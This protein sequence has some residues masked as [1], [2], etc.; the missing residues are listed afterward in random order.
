MVVGVPPVR[1]S[2]DPSALRTRVVRH[3]ASA[4]VSVAAAAAD[5]RADGAL[6]ALE[7]GR[8]PEVDL[9]LR[10]QDAE[11]V[12]RRHFR[13]QQP[14]RLRTCASRPGAIESSSTRT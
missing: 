10:R 2:I 7:I 8:R 5:E 4:S 12:A 13:H 6:H 9:S 1:A 14:D 11:L 3:W